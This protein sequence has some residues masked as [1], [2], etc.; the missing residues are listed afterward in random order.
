MVKTAS[1]DVAQYAEKHYFCKVIKQVTIYH[2]GII[3][4][5]V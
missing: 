5:T 3:S 2:I 1:K 4:K